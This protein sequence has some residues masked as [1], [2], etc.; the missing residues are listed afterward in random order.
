MPSL[1]ALPQQTD[2]D[3]LRPL[4]LANDRPYAVAGGFLPVPIPQRATCKAAR[5]APT[6]TGP[7][8]SVAKQSSML[9]SPQISSSGHRYRGGVTCCVS[10]LAA[11][12]SPPTSFQARYERNASILLRGPSQLAHHTQASRTGL[13]KSCWVSTGTRPDINQAL[14]IVLLV[15]CTEMYHALNLL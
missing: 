11:C 13:V 1:A 5:Q 4:M 6:C 7:H 12:I 3:L 8:Q 9:L 15:C 2:A 14:R 10:G